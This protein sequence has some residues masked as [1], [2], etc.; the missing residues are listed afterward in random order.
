MYPSQTS[1]IWPCTSR[2]LHSSGAG[3]VPLACLCSMAA[4]CTR[5]AYG[6]EWYMVEILESRRHFLQTEILKLYGLLQAVPKIYVR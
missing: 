5:P 2:R 4:P 3:H 1:S 6:G